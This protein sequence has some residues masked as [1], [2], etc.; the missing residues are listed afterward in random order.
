[1]LN[2]LRPTSFDGILGQNDVIERLKIST[3][4]AIMTG[5]A[6]PHILFSGPPGLGKTTL[7]LATAEAMNVP[8]AVANGGNLRAIKNILPYLMNIKENSILFIDEIHRMTIIVEE[9]LYPVM[10]D[11]RMDIGG[12]KVSISLPKFTL[13]GATTVSG[14]ISAPLFDR[15]IYHYI[16]NLYPVEAILEILEVNAIKLKLKIEKSALKSLA[17]RCR[18]TPRHANNHLI[19][20]RDYSNA[21]GILIIT[22][23]TIDEAMQMIGIDVDGTTEQDRRYLAALQRSDMPLGINT[24]V[25][26]TGID[27]CTIE[28]VIEPFLLK[29]GKIQKTPRGRIAV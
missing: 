29:Q 1:M 17:N 19:W 14:Q 2:E 24:L 22:E 25:G 23:K 4:S 3:D 6:L 9:F 20:L 21:E 12:N 11:F 28:E 5:E 18:G 7:A 16:L 10:E 26:F 13:I 8:I 15:F 27:K